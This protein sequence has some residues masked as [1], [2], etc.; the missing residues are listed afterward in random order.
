MFCVGTIYTEEAMKEHT[1]TV[2]NQLATT[3]RSQEEE[4]RYAT[5]WFKLMAAAQHTADNTQASTN[6]LQLFDLHSCD[7]LLCV[8]WVQKIRTHTQT[9]KKPDQFSTVLGESLEIHKMYLM[10]EYWRSRS[11]QSLSNIRS[12]S[13]MILMF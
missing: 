13:F 2:A 1:D 12:C 3:S 4:W 7:S 11:K 8:H 6:S 9:E 5:Q 10:F